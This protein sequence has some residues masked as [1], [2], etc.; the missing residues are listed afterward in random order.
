MRRAG[1]ATVGDN[2]VRGQGAILAK[3]RT[4][5]FLLSPANMRES[6]DTGVEYTCRH[7]Q[8]TYQRLLRSTRSSTVLPISQI[9][10]DRLPSRLRTDSTDFI[11]GPFLLSVSVL[12][13]L[14][15]ADANIIFYSCGFY[16]SSSFFLAYSQRSEIRCLPYFLT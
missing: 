11:T 14:C 15:V 3:A 5:P 16:L 1:D 12:W 2:A 10:P 6:N 4:T 9:F 8:S 13:P 7:E